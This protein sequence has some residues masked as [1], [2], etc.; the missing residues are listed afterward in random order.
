MRML[1]MRGLGMER[2]VNLA[3]KERPDDLAD[4]LTKLEASVRNLAMSG[5][6]AD[7]GLKLRLDRIERE[8]L[9]IKR[10]LGIEGAERMT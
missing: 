6:G 2:R 3:K 4:R 7:N 10:K 5:Q 9:E 8:I 1:K